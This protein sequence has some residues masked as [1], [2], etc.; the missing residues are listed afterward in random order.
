MLPDLENEVL[1]GV[2]M[3]AAYMREIG[4]NMNDRRCFSWIAAGR[5]PHTKV[6]AQI[7]SSKSAIRNRFLNSIE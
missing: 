4:F 3:I 6:G 7:I 1:H 5:I 2:R